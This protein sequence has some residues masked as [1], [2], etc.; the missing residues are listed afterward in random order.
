MTYITCDLCLQIKNSEEDDTYLCTKCNCLF[1]DTCAEKIS[2][3]LSVS[4]GQLVI[5]ECYFC[6][7]DPNN[8]I[9]TEDEIITY[10]LAQLNLS[11]NDVENKIKEKIPLKK[12]ISDNKIK[13]NL[14]FNQND[15]DSSFLENLSPHDNESESEYQE[16]TEI[17][18]DSDS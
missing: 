9:I 7:S 8:R 5:E 16:F 13:L 2:N 12:P 3:K 1:C 10:C 14:A 18:D 15:S 6:C 4:R 11:R 17:S